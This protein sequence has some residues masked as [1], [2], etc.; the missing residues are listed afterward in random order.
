M[1]I[2]IAYIGRGLNDRNDTCCSYLLPCP[3]CPGVGGGGGGYS[4]LNLPGCVSMKV[5]DT[6]QFLAPTE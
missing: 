5:M 4:A 6:G 3:I 1:T 2:L